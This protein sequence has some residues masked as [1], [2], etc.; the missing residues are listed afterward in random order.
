VVTRRSRARARPRR[1]A[2]RRRLARRADGRSG[3]GGAGRLVPGALGD[4]TS[5][6]AV[7]GFSLGVGVSLAVFVPFVR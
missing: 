3:L 7:V 5:G 1:A 4:H 2:A 6:Q